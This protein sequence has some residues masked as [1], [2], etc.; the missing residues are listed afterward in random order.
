MFH[1]TSA[2][3]STL[4][5]SIEYQGSRA[6]FIKEATRSYCSSGLTLTSPPPGGLRLKRDPVSVDLRIGDI[7][8]TFGRWDEKA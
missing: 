2:S 7:G 6:S 5:K 1:V 4:A 8:Q 3:A